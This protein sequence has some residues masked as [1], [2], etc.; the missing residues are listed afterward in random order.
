MKKESYKLTTKDLIEDLQDDFDTV[1][2]YYFL[3]EIIPLENGN[4]KFRITNLED[5]TNP[6]AES[7]KEFKTIKKLINCLVENSLFH[8][9]TEKEFRTKTCLT[10]LR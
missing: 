1:S 5:E 10:F 3:F 9:K 7:K 2:D 8:T 4:Y 6:L